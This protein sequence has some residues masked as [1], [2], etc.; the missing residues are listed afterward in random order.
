[1]TKK[2]RIIRFITY[3]RTQPVRIRGKLRELIIEACEYKGGTF[4]YKLR[5][6]NYLEPELKSIEKI[7]QDH[8]DGKIKML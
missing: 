7:L 6:Q 5:N 8:K 2:T 3:Y 1:M 4:D